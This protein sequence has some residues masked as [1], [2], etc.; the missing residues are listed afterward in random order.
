M[1]VL[2]IRQLRG[3]ASAAAAELPSHVAGHPLE[4]QDCD[5]LQ[6]LVR[7]LQ[8]AHRSQ[9]AWV[10]IENGSTDA[11]QWA[12][13]GAA[14]GKALEALPAPYIE[15]AGNDADTLDAHLHPQHAAAA[16]IV[17]NHDTARACQ[18]SLAIAARRLQMNEERS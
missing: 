9:P 2:L 18:L 12:S 4:C 11:E 1:S 3:P 7:C 17:C 14:V 6:A 8:H 5:S 16:L 13:H 15:I 10:L